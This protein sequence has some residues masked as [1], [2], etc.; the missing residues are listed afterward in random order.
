MRVTLVCGGG[1]GDSHWDGDCRSYKKKI[2][3]EQ[4]KWKKQAYRWYR[5]SC[6]RCCGW[7]HVC[8]WWALSLKAS[9]NH[10]IC[11]GWAWMTWKKKSHL[12]PPLTITWL[13]YF[14]TVLSASSVLINHNHNLNGL[15]HNHNHNHYHYHHHHNN[16]NN[17]SGHDHNPT[18]TT[19]SLFGFLYLLH[20]FFILA[21][22]ITSNNHNPTPSSTQHQHHPHSNQLWSYWTQR[23]SDGRNSSRDSRHIASRVT[24]KFF[25]LLYYLFLLH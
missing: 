5:C 20:F 7:C 22:T 14:H 8:G 19:V 9:N 23:N 24:G 12:S 21:M 11:W 10:V 18:I 16:N 3:E 4:K 15:N 1:G 25:F 2:S 6:G 17:K 13:C